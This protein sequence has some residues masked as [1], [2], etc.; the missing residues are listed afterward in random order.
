MELSQWGGVPDLAGRSMEI[1]S[2]L[3]SFLTCVFTHRSFPE[4]KTSGNLPMPLPHLL[5]VL[6]TSG[7]GGHLKAKVAAQ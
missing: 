1:S 7:W 3:L 5:L 4:G 2:L 6:C